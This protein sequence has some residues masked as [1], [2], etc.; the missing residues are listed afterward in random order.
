MTGRGK[1]GAQ[2]DLWSQAGIIVVTLI[3]I[4]V[5]FTAIEIKWSLSHLAQTY[6]QNTA[7]IEAEAKETEE[8]RCILKPSPDKEECISEAR[9]TAQNEKR[10]EADLYAQGKM[11]EW[12]FAVGVTAF[13]S[14]F[15]SMAGIFFVLRSLALN[16]EAIAV[17]ERTLV[18]Q[19]RPYLYVE[20]VKFKNPLFKGSGDGLRVQ[21][22]SEVIFEVVNHTDVPALIKKLHAQVEIAVEITRSVN[23]LPQDTHTT[24]KMVKRNGTQKIWALNRREIPPEQE[25]E[26]HSGD[27]VFNEFKGPKVFVFGY[28]QY[29]NPFG[30]TDEVG[31]CWQYHVSSGRF[32]QSENNE[33]NYRKRNIGND[34]PLVGPPS[35]LLALPT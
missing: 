34:K 24:E 25:S 18:E 28:I 2:N 17:A 19:D 5:G 33:W 8:H 12:A 15:L 7:K 31:F 20:D 16:R 14:V 26:I 10:D 27:H 1:N 23:M 22:H 6:Q 9:K 30:V 35:S 29:E 32:I 11:A 3:S 21:Q 4:A 13:I